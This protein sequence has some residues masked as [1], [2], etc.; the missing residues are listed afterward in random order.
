MDTHDHTCGE[1]HFVLEG[2]YERDGA[3]Y[4]AA[5]YACIP[6]RAKHGPFTSREGAVVL[7]VWEG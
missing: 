2:E 7:V 4:T 1:Q 3:E 6:A 5:T